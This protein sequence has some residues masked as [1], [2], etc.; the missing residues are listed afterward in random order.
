[1]FN[2]GQ[3]RR[4]QLNYDNYL[5][6][7]D[8]TIDDIQASSYSLEMKF[9]DKV[10]KVPSKMTYGQNYY[11]RLAINKNSNSHQKITMQLRNSSVTDSNIQTLQTY[12]IPKENSINEKTTIIQFVISPNATYD[13]IILH[14]ERNNQDFNI[15]HEDSIYGR[16]IE[17]RVESFGTITNLLGNAITPHVLTKMGVQGPPGLLMC[18]NGQGIRIGPSGIYQ[19]NNGYQ[20]NFLGFIVLMSDET[21]DKRDFFILDYQYKQEE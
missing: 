11:I 13:Q 7:L 20:V 3:F 15:H 19:I 4:D 2:L 17:F 6:P 5:S 16:I 10:I 9:N 21:P 12:Y 1:M 18:I 14:L 8:Y